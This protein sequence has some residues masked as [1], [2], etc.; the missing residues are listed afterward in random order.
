[1]KINW[2]WVSEISSLLC[3]LDSDNMIDISVEELALLLESIYSQ[4][5]SNDTSSIDWKK[6]LTQAWKDTGW[7]NEPSDELIKIFKDYSICMDK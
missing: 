3:S 6:V 2:I 7:E 5:V 4:T 1:M